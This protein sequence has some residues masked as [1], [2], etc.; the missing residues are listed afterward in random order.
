MGEHRY[1]NTRFSLGERT[2]GP[3]WLAASLPHLR[4]RTISSHGEK[5]QDA[6]ETS[7]VG[8]V[9]FDNRVQFL[10][11]GSEVLVAHNALSSLHPVHVA[12]EGIDLSVVGQVPGNQF[13]ITV[14]FRFM[15]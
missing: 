15:C 6:I 3:G 9:G 1:G 13:H 8:Q 4:Q 2:P 12:A 7:R 14:R 11:I 10:E 5:L